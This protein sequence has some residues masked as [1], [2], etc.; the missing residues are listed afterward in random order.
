MCRGRGTLIVGM[1]RGERS[2]VGD[3]HGAACP[4][5]CTVMKVQDAGEDEERWPASVLDTEEDEELRTRVR[6][7]V[8]D[9]GR[10][11][12]ARAR[13]STSSEALAPESGHV[14]T[15]ASQSAPDAVVG[16]KLVRLESRCA[17]LEQLIRTLV[18]QNVE[19]H[20]YISRQRREGVGDSTGDDEACGNADCGDRVEENDADVDSLMSQVEQLNVL[21]SAPELDAM[22]ESMTWLMA[23]KIEN[24][25]EARRRQRDGEGNALGSSPPIDD[26]GYPRVPLRLM[27]EQ[28]GRLVLD[29]AD[30]V[31]GRPLTI[32]YDAAARD[33]DS[34]AARN[35]GGALSFH[36]GFNDWTLGRTIVNA[37]LPREVRSRD[38][39][40]QTLSASDDVL[41]LSGGGEYL[42]DWYVATVYIPVDAK[43]MEVL[44]SDAKNELLLDNNDGDRFLYAVTERRNAAMGGGDLPHNG[45]GRN[46]NRSEGSSTREIDVAELE[47]HRI[48]QEGRTRVKSIIAMLE[49]EQR[50]QDMHE[51]QDIESE[52]ECPLLE[53]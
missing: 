5:P 18:K 23:I 35:G 37:G 50:A 7:R 31:A 32:M 6:E 12:R 3:G 45:D 49:E 11:A 39:D 1:A 53:T 33:A 27:H 48:I 15:Q 29:P 26:D 16:E 43:A 2:G 25:R 51:A 38:V 52:A 13:S 9:V 20:D 22:R 44:V 17:G 46:G 19:L 42:G 21:K 47:N 8:A 4:E 41:L 36:V 30:P 10:R 28:R 14:N 40:N 34:L 24:E